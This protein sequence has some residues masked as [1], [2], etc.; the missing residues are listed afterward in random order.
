MRQ[1][2]REGKIVIFKG[3]PGFTWWSNK[4]MIKKP[5]REIVEVARKNITFPLASYLVGA[6][7]YSYFCYTWGWLGQYGTFDHYPEYD[8][9]LGA[10]KGE[11]NR[12]GYKYSREFEHA[13]VFVDL[14]T[15]DAR[16]D[17]K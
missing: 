15:K 7:P 8:K 1:A 5:H 2:S 6:G 12:D 11:A 10:P 16:I 4:E 13:S 9:P 3:W 14:E 17:W